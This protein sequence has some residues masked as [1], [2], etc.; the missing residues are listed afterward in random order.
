[1]PLLRK[2]GV[3]AMMLFAS[4]DDDLSHAIMEQTAWTADDE[5]A[6]PTEFL[7]GDEP[8]T[9]AKRRGRELLAEGGG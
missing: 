4:S 8:A 7:P 1:M 2:A 5:P 9:K 6:A 3:E